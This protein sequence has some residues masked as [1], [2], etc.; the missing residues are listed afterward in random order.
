MSALDE[1]R[2]W[3]RYAQEDLLAAESMIGQG[4]RSLC[5]DLIVRKSTVR[6]VKDDHSNH[7]PQPA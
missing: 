2:R 6:E 1:T 5:Y 4:Q 3:R 7:Y